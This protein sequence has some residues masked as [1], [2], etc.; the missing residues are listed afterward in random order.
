MEEQKSPRVS[1]SD[2]SSDHNQKE[3][4]YESGEG[5]DEDPGPEPVLSSESE[6]SSS[7]SDSDEELASAIVFPAQ[8]YHKL[9][10]GLNRSSWVVH[11]NCLIECERVAAALIRSPDR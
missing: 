9:N 2:S 3:I 6:A 10:D 1:A 4:G 11:I 8:Q 7:T 5:V